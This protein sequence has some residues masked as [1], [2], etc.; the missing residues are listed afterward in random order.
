MIKLRVVFRNLLQAN[1]TLV[2]NDPII[3]KDVQDKWLALIKT[4]VEAENLSFP[5]AT[6]LSNAVGK[7]QFICYFY[8]SDVAYATAI[9]IR[10]VLLD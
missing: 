2:W 7:P 10:W 1:S 9:Y 5:R 4:L 6:T 3:D 8:G